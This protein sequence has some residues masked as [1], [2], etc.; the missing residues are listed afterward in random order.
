VQWGKGRQAALEAELDRIKRLAGVSEI[1]F[2]PDWLKPS[3]QH[4]FG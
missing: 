1:A 3:I 4:Q 2:E